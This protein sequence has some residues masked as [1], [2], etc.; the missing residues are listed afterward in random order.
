MFMRKFASGL[1]LVS[2]T[3]FIV[4]SIVFCFEMKAWGFSQMEL[5]IIFIVSIFLNYFISCI[6]V[7]YQNVTSTLILS[8]VVMI[9]F[10]MLQIITISFLSEAVQAFFLL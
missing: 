10:V 2:L 4:M 7:K 8:S 5:S 9:L 6:V 1:S 3:I